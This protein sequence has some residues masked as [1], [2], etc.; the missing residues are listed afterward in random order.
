L[1]ENEE[2]KT[3]FFQVG[4]GIGVSIRKWVN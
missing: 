3:Y 2:F 1:K 4:D